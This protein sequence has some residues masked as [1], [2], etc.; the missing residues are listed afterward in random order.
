MGNKTECTGFLARATI[1]PETKAGLDKTESIML[2]S[3]SWSCSRMS[4]LMEN[5]SF[6]FNVSRG[7]GLLLEAVLKGCLPAPSRVRKESP[8]FQIHSH[9]CVGKSGKIRGGGEPP[10][11]KASLAIMPR[12]NWETCG[13]AIGKESASELLES[14]EVHPELTPELPGSSGRTQ[15]RE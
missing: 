1:K 7:C 6:P 13:F 14:M 15:H 12:G 10:S 2:C 11:W 4:L 3:L 9:D 5:R 8:D